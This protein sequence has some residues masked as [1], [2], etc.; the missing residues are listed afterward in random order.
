MIRQPT[1]YPYANTLLQVLYGCVHAILGEH[2]TGMYLD[3]SLN[4]LAMPHFVYPG[5]RRLRLQTRR[6]VLG[7]GDPGRTLAPFD[8]LCL[9]GTP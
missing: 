2:I 3:G 7:A 1:P 5:T 9:G 8:H 6:G 4:A